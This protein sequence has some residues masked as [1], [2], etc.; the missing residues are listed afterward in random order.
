MAA[1]LG[2]KLVFLVATLQ[3]HAQL[4]SVGLKLKEIQNKVIFDF[5]EPVSQKIHEY[6]FYSPE[7]S[8]KI[9]ERFFLH[10]DQLKLIF[11]NNNIPAELRYA[12]ISM[13][14]CEQNSQKDPVKKG[15]YNLS[16]QTSKKHGLFLSNYI[17]ERF[18][19][20]KSAEAFCKEMKQIQKRHSNWRDALVVFCV[21][22]ALW[23]KAKILS[24]DSTNDFFRINAHLEIKYRQV[25]YDYV[26]AVYIVNYFKEL[27][28]KANL[29]GKP[30]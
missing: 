15:W 19:I 26:A 1:R 27:K 24:G 4:D 2:F 3:V 20:L 14:G 18:D 12:C 30:I 9:L 7:N 16:Y 21:G 8:K 28:K 22:D 11:K 25:Y 5:S 10:D 23:Q 17:D 6:I 29:Q 13:T